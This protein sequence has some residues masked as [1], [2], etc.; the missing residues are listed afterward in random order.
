MG[1]RLRLLFVVPFAI[2]V[3]FA[4]QTASAVA[5]SGQV[6]DGRGVAVSGAMVELTNEAS[7]RSFVSD[8][9]DAVGTY[10]IAV[11]HLWQFWQA[12]QPFPMD[13]TCRRTIRIRSI[14]AT[15][16]GFNL[17]H[18]S[19]VRWRSTTAWVISCTSCS[20]ANVRRGDIG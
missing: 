19:D 11:A 9:T 17:E 8:T 15:L 5:V 16:I 18:P 2:P 1:I 7:G 13:S 12:P 4:V 6:T 20:M 3:L 10:L 14:P